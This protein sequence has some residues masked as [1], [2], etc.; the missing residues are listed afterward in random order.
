MRQRYSDAREDLLTLVDQHFGIKN[1]TREDAKNNS[2]QI[3]DAL[4]ERQDE[5]IIALFDGTNSFQQ[6]SSNFEYQRRSYSGEKSRNLYKPFLCVS[7]N[8]YIIDVFGP[9]SSNESEG[10]ILNNLI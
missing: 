2:T 3:A 5:A 8:G 9:Y 6:K 7:P 1:I 10:T 4:L